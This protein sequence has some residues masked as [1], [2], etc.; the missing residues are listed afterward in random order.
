MFQPPRCPYRPCSNHL[1][2]KVDAFLHHGHYHPKCRPHPVPRFRCRA[3]RHTFSRQTFRM[4]YRDHRPDLNARLFRSIASGLGLR[5]S[6]RNLHL[7]LRC[8]EL[9]FR[10]IARH[11]RRLN[12]NLRSELPGNASFQLDEF[13]TFE[14]R[15]NTRPLS[16]PV[17]IE[18][19]TQ[20]IVWAESATI[21]P[22]GT[23][24]KARRAALAEDEARFGRRR[25]CSR[26]SLRRTLARAAALVS[27]RQK[28]LFETDKKS[29]YVELA[30]ETFG[31]D[32]LVH[33][34]TSSRLPRTVA[35]PLFPINHTEAMARDLMGRLR[36]ESW[37][38]SKARRYLDL[39]LHVFMAYR[40]LVR[41][42]FNYDDA[43]PAQMLGF[44]PRRF[45]ETEVLG[46]RQDWGA[47]SQ[48][49]LAA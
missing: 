33:E 12:L 34:R 16:V 49:P 4:D 19:T 27:T 28:V 46:W 45:T 37:L 18:K 30:R 39:G 1:E 17:L 44:A 41:L 21:R 9:K 48:H 32:R 29:S 10:K 6:S 26:R 38:V 24:T 7:S 25:D 3:C 47:K 35:N 15:R 11:L 8:T 36:R 42:R 31:R 40:N 43:S 5:Q 23:M 22:R 2:P 20:F 13:E 14:G